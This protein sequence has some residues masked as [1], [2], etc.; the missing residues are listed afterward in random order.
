[1]GPDIVYG[2][3]PVAGRYN[4]VTVHGVEWPLHDRTLPALLTSTGW[5]RFAKAD[6]NC[7]D[8]ISAKIYLNQN[9]ATG[10]DRATYIEIF[11]GS[12]AGSPANTCYTSVSI[13]YRD[14][15]NDELIDPILGDEVGPV[16]E[17]MICS[18]EKVGPS[19]NL[20]RPENVSVIGT[21]WSDYFSLTATHSG[22]SLKMV[23]PRMSPARYVTMVFER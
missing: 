2:E 4:L 12:S 23:V 15:V 20:A 14:S 17:R 1:M 7:C 11:D 19:I 22:D 5:Y 18:W 8:S 6:S 16:T 9:Y 3:G 21:I 13:N 10:S